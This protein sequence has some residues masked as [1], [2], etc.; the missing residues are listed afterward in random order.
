MSAAPPELPLSERLPGARAGRAAVEIL[1]AMQQA[2]A[3]PARGYTAA[4]EVLARELRNARALRSPERRYVSD[5]LHDILRAQR[6]LRLL[7]GRKQPEARQVYAAWLLDGWR[8]AE[9]AAEA[10]PPKLLVQIA[11]ETG[12]DVPALL[13]RSAELH[14]L[15]PLLASLPADEQVARAGEVLSYP[16]WLVAAVL[17]DLGPE[18]GLSVLRAQ[19]RR[20]PLTARANLLRCTREALLE[21]LA[22]EGVTA[23]PTPHA[24]HGLIFHAGTRVNAY[25][26]PS[27]AEG[28]FELQ[29]EGSQLLAEV[30]APPPG[31]T[32]VDACAGAGGKTLAL[33]AMLR[34]RG[35]LVAS[36]VD[37]H[38][39]TE[40]GKR[41][42]R[43]GLTNVQSVWASASDAPAPSRGP[44]P[45]P[46]SASV[47]LKGGAS[48][49]LVDA[50]C[51]G[52]GVL[53]RHP[54]ARW[55]LGPRD[56][57]EIG[58]KQ[59]EILAASAR[60][61]EPHGRLIYATCTI[62]ARENDAVVHEFLA[63]HPDFAPV[64]V[65]EILGGARA[66]AVTDADGVFLRVYPG[67]SPESPDGFFAAVLR[68]QK[69]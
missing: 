40:L 66:Q 7:C 56:L 64:P 20:A 37:R 2:A 34:N 13:A 32:V 10:R 21:R 54:E 63:A 48:R 33:G 14:R 57:D 8:G 31:G 45:P 59:R 11:T 28:W 68:R 35:R 6:R 44:A 62:L 16:D 36:D 18:R 17:S 69:A 15:E 55:R 39:L 46:L 26:L 60:L 43:A 65:K 23:H 49:V 9:G 67:E 53:R 41:A 19:N 24:P 1:D 52:L 58:K 5:A 22:A 42:R 50:P 12:L 47:N 30:V 27:F 4:A 38:K 3:D 51:S 25:A 29:D 61:V